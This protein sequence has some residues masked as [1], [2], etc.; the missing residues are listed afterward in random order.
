LTNNFA[1][2]DE[3]LQ[4][5]PTTAIWDESM[6][7]H[8]PDPLQLFVAPA[9]VTVSATR[10]EK[11]GFVRAV[12]SPGWWQG[13]EGKPLLTLS[14]LLAAIQTTTGN[15]KRDIETVVLPFLKTAKSEAM[16]KSVLG[17]KPS[18]ENVSMKIVKVGRGI[19][20][21]LA[22]YGEMLLFFR[23]SSVS[24]CRSPQYFEECS[25]VFGSLRI[26]HS[27]DVELPKDTANW[28]EVFG[29]SWDDFREKP[30][31]CVISGVEKYGVFVDAVD[32]NENVIRGISGLVHF[33]RSAM[34]SSVYVFFFYVLKSA[35]FQAFSF[36][37]QV[38]RN[39]LEGRRIHTS[40]Q[41]WMVGWQAGVGEARMKVWC[42][43]KLS[44]F[45][46]I[47]RMCSE[48]CLSVGFFHFYDVWMSSKQTHVVL[49]VKTQNTK[50][51]SVFHSAT[52][53]ISK[54]PLKGIGSTRPDVQA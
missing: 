24:F 34:F 23:V 44:L 13:G 39:V 53:L 18:N 51:D 37:S 36:W 43:L 50:S 9:H 54:S 47:E 46:F 6:L 16:S 29:L 42:V 7:T 5:A 15:A 2:N 22:K 40:P 52:T 10:L 31:R 17:N 12:A 32:G 8:R 45:N 25:R 19:V 48:K 21:R 20:H 30:T 35:L 33:S 4:V 41:Y 38:E 3:R 27:E 28:K 49:K 1:S 26:T 11:I 14:T